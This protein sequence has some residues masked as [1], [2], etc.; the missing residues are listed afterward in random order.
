MTT[1]I[2]VIFIFLATSFFLSCC[3][4][5]TY[6]THSVYFKRKRK[7][8]FSLLRTSPLFYSKYKTLP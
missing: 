4:P 5:P 1:F 7:Q 6:P 8:P 3:T 2:L